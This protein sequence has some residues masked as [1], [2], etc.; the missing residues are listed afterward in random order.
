[1]ITYIYNTVT[2]NIHSLATDLSAGDSTAKGLIIVGIIGALVALMRSVPK[3]IKK[4]IIRKYTIS[5]KAENNWH[6]K[7][8][9]IFRAIA[10]FVSANQ[11]NKDFIV[12]SVKEDKKY[13]KED[14]YLSPDY[15][16]GF[17]FHNKRPYY[18]TFEQ[19]K[20]QGA[21]AEALTISTL[22]QNPEIIWNDIDLINKINADDDSR[23]FYTV[24]KE[25]WIEVDDMSKSSVIFLPKKLK[26][27]LDKKLDFFMN[28]KDWYI[29]RGISH[30]LLIILYGPPGCGKS[31]LA[32]Y[33][34]DYLGQSLGTLKDGFYFN[35]RMRNAAKKN[36]VVSIPDF[37][38]LNIASSRGDIED[39]DTNIVSDNVANKNKT[40]NTPTQSFS[41]QPNTLSE[42]LNTFQ[43][44]LPLNGSVT[45]M[46]TNCINSIDKALLRRGR[47]DLL[48]ELGPLDYEPVNEF[49]KHHYNDAV[50]LGDSY[51]NVSI[52]ACDIQGIFE[53]YPFN[54]DS[55]KEQLKNYIK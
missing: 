55:F 37:D 14:I 17:F 9:Q 11:V 25:E 31:R 8:R 32:R 19:S 21:V 46:S 20:E 30:K 39:D 45:V 24:E 22:G 42:V 2:E 49:Y 40:K 4:L 47:C 1:M 43:G 34:A 12:F 52:K 51:K 41:T 7:N 26:E 18:Y 29:E 6:G 15:S 38:V 16:S 13:T 35:Q 50:D 53:D 44:D 27:E 10:R 36:I 23:K 48:L 3:Y 5:I 33:V 54:K 28:N